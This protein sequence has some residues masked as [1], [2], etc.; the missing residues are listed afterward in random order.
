VVSYGL[1]EVTRISYEEVIVGGSAVCSISGELK[2]E[3]H[4]LP[5]TCRHF[6]MGSCMGFLIVVYRLGRCCYTITFSFK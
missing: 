6:C 5:I 3:P 4:L 2:S 1:I